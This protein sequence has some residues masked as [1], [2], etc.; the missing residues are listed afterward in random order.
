MSRLKII[1]PHG[2][3]LYMDTIL[4][5]HTNKLSVDILC[6][7]GGIQIARYTPLPEKVEPALRHTSELID[8]LNHQYH[9]YLGLL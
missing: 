6:V 7:D 4:C 3:Y 1:L 2:E 8:E 5:I 9:V